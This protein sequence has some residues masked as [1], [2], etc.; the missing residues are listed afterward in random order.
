MPFGS[1]FSLAYPKLRLGFYTKR[2]PWVDPCGQPAG[3]RFGS[4]P[5][6]A[7][8]ALPDFQ[9]TEE[10]LASGDT[11]CPVWIEHFKIGEEAKKLPCE[12]LYHK[13]C[14]VTWL[15]KCNSCPVCRFELKSCDLNNERQ[16]GVGD[17]QPAVSGAFGAAGYRWQGPPERF[18][19]ELRW[20]IGS[21]N[22]QGNS[23]SGIVDA[24]ELVKEALLKA[25]REN[26]DG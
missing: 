2:R 20:P 5:P 6:S 9:L 7:I 23:G 11:Q 3:R 21:E 19:I 4:A 14:I 22:G 12:H 25:A 1:R 26:G 16:S 18:N 10:L 15:E 8:A 13:N 17:P 24:S